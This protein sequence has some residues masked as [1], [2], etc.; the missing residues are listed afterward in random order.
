MS[1]PALLLDP[2][3]RRSERMRQLFVEYAPKD[4][5]AL[6]RT[7]S[8]GNPAEIAKAA[9]RLKGGSYTFGAVRM[10]DAAAEVE[11]V[12]RS[13]QV[14]GAAAVGELAEALKATLEK[15]AA[16]PP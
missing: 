16:L 4:F 14:P 7:L 15:L 13:G 11:R 12:A 6:E 2:E 8:E 5:A 9:H 10:G 1:G 3:V